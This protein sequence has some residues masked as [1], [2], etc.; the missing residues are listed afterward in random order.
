M[1]GYKGFLTR[2]YLY[3]FF[4]DFAFIYAVY[5]VL[6]KLRGLSV[7]EISLL[8]SLWAALNVVLEIPTG[9][10]ADRW[11]RKYM[12]VLGML[13]KAA[14]FLVWVFA[15]DFVMFALG[16]LF[17]TIQSTFT[18]GTQ[19]AL[20]YDTLKKFRKYREYKRVTGTGKFYQKI[21]T[22]AACLLGGV[23]ASVSF[24]AVLVLSSASMIIAMIAALTFQEVKV[25]TTTKETKYL[26]LI[27]NAIIQS[28]KNKLL[29]RMML[30]SMI[31]L[32]IIGAL[33]EYDQLFLNWVD[34]PIFLFGAWFVARFASE[35]VAG[36]IAYRVERYFKTDKIIYILS[37]LAGALLFLSI[38]YPSVYMLP[39]YLSVYF[40]IAISDV[41]VECG[42]QE[43][44]KTN[45]RA[46]ILSINR[47]MENA[48]CIVFFSV[49][50]LLSL[51]GGLYLGLLFFAILLVAYSVAAIIRY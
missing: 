9:A 20:L 37:G 47:F 22:G 31:V 15:N 5:V 18:S 4:K 6:F 16:F 45:E 26:L 11:N 34:V 46:T 36:R 17:W 2:F 38:S 32:S 28:A 51:A 12:L 13:S 7:L 30:Y 3:R 25:R 40:L 35:A 24:D 10:L 49:F 41:F 48:S 8:L 23:I 29:L 43:Q 21:A 27:K 1:Y 50:G 39:V 42:L 33:D 44:I 19:E 14:G